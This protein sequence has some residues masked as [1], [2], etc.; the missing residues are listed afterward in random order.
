M[1]AHARCSGEGAESGS[2]SGGSA[3]DAPPAAAT[4]SA[5]HGHASSRF[6]TAS[7]PLMLHTPHKESLH[8]QHPQ[9]MLQQRSTA[10]AQHSRP[11]TSSHV[12]QR[13]A[14]SQLHSLQLRDH[15]HEGSSTAPA[16]TVR[17][18]PRD[19]QGPFESVKVAG[20]SRLARRLR[21]ERS[22]QQHTQQ[23]NT[24]RTSERPRHRRTRDS[25]KLSAFDLHQ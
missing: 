22:T 16:R 13:V 20:S 10:E 7:K 24:S 9:T 18:A 5:P 3:R 6:S 15:D 12:H 1:Q 25:E 2:A 4:P 19:D 17:L 11:G 21:G 14:T 23:Q 8:R